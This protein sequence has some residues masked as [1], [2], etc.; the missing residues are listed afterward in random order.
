MKMFEN[1]GRIAEGLCSQVQCDDEFRKLKHR[2]V[3]IN[4]LA[5]QEIAIWHSQIRKRL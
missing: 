4:P 2:V 3:E 5:V 1:L